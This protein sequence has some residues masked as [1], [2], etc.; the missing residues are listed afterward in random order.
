MYDPE[1]RAG[2]F[3]WYLLGPLL[4]PTLGPLVGGVVVENLGWRWVFWIMAIICTS[5]TLL[6]FFF[7]KESY[8]PVILE[9][10]KNDISRSHPET[11]FCFKG[12]DDRPILTKLK[13]SMQRPLRILFTQPIV[14]TMALYQAII[15]GTTYSLYTNFQDI[16]GTEYGFTTT[17]VG[18][19]YLGPGLGFLTAVWFVVPKIDTVYNR[20]TATNNGNSK[21]EFRLPIANIG[22]ILI[23]I[24]LFWFAWTV[25]YHVHWFPTLLSTFFFGV[26]Q[27]TIFNTVQNYYIDCFTE[28]AASAIAAGAVFR[29]LLGG[30]VPLFVPSMIKAFGYGW[31]LST[32][33]FASLAIAPSPLLFYYFGEKLRARYA[34]EL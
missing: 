10:R 18:L 2:I 24:S 15:F 8:A 9:S 7:L 1:V 20:L 19:L 22:S 25:E 12:E 14:F 5:N 4:G 27:V 30:I 3:G 34:I 26:G 17:Q 23:P 31:G 21:P 33:A 13:H 11:K 29:S 28:Y 16:W 6:A 32:F